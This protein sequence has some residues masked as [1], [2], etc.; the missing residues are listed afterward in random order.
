MWLWAGLV[1]CG[2]VLTSLY[3]GPWMWAGLGTMFALT[4][5]LTFLVPVLRKPGQ[6]GEETV[7]SEPT[8]T[9]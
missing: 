4:V 7:G 8:G 1:S 3:S 6:P 5:A 9:L 2:A